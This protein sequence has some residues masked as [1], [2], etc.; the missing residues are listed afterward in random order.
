[1]QTILIATVALLILY[2]MLK[3]TSRISPPQKKERTLSKADKALKHAERQLVQVKKSYPFKRKK[4]LNDTEFSALKIIERVLKN[5]NASRFIYVL[6]QVALGSY[7]THSI[8]YTHQAINTKRTDFLLV[9]RGYY[10]VAAI[11]INGSGHFISP[12]AQL[13]DEIK[14]RALEGAE[15]E[16]IS[17]EYE[18]TD[19]LEDRFNL[20]NRVKK[21]ICNYKQERPDLFQY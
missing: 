15:I 12:T 20:E 13:R 1:M 2:F 5:E 21:F 16:F 6:P 19:L 18:G 10:P 8:E 3:R 7:L 17:V 11:E 14:L 4:L 9:N